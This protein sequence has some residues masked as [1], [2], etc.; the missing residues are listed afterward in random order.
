MNTST[1]SAAVILALGLGLNNVASATE[2]SMSHQRASEARTKNQPAMEQSSH[3]WRHT[4]DTPFRYAGRARM[5]VMRSPMMLG[6][7]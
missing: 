6:E 3:G 5:S 1:R 7:A 4:V 2:E